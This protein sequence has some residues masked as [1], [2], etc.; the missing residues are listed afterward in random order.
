M[1]GYKGEVVSILVIGESC[2]DIFWYGDSSRMC[3][4]APAPVFN[5]LHYTDNGGMAMNV[6][7]NIEA[8]GYNC[9]IIT[10]DNWKDITKTR[11]VHKHTNSLFIR[12]DEGDDKVPRCKLSKINF[13][14]YDLIVIS[15]YNKG[16][17]LQ[18]D[19]EYIARNHSCVFLDT[20]KDLG[21]WCDHVNYIKINNF[22]YE[23]AK[24]RI[25]PRMK[26]KMI[27]TLGQEGCL[28][29]NEIFP[30]E[31]VEIKDVSGAGDTFLA[32]LVV[33]YLKT[34]DV[35]TAAIFANACASLVVQ[36]RGVSTCQ[37]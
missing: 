11:Y 37:K 4:E 22:E 13:S 19:V 32:G 10:N 20:K 17:L 28:Y 23:R 33:E 8:L 1:Q 15:D 26:E 2:R 18:E 5:P 14:M 9:D 31:K 16:F 35:A 24:S 7:I 25:T 34:R 21:P 6:K 27:V 3:P 36:K 12:V 29:N 30:V